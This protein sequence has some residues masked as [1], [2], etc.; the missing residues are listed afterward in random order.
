MATRPIPLPFHQRRN[1]YKATFSSRWGRGWW[2]GKLDRSP[3]GLCQKEPSP[4][5]CLNYQR[6]PHISVHIKVNI[7]Q[8]RGKQGRAANTLELYCKFL[9]YVHQKLSSCL[10]QVG[11]GRMCHVAAPRQRCRSVAIRAATVLCI[12]ANR[13]HASGSPASRS[14]TFRSTHTGRNS[15]RGTR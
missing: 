3:H 6:A 15:H 9:R 7:I 1:T 12:V 8:G 5:P 14:T 10:T 4:P 13:K 2:C 11:P